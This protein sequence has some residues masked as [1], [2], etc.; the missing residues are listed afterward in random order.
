MPSQSHR[1]Q[2]FESQRYEAKRI[3]HVTD[4][5]QRVPLAHLGKRLLQYLTAH[6]Y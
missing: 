1:R 5:Y 4:D 2:K 3:Q 6:D